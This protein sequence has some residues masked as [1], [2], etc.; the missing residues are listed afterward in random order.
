MPQETPSFMDK[1][2]FV[3]LCSFF[4]FSQFAQD[5]TEVSDLM[6]INH[7]VSQLLA[8]KTKRPLRLTNNYRT[9]IRLLTSKDY[10]KI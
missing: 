7:I 6:I 5:V 3:L 8:M 1:P 2:V 9:R 4:I 10:R